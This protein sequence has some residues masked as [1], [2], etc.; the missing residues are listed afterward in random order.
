M[1]MGNI[2]K[3]HPNSLRTNLPITVDTIWKLAI[4][5]QINWLVSMCEEHWSLI[6]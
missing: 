4:A 5:A 1:F 6:D 3:E 2:N